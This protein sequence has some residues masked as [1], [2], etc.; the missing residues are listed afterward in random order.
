MKKTVKIIRVNLQERSISN[1]VWRGAVVE[2]LVQLGYGAESGRIAWVRG[3]ASP[4][5]D[6]N[7]LSVNPAVNGYLFRI[8]EG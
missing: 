1:V 5:G 4:C 7:T 2:W 8:R 6:W 3:S